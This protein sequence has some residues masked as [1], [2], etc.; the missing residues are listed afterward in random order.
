[1][2]VASYKPSSELSNL[3]ETPQT[4]TSTR[5]LRQQSRENKSLC[6][7][8]NIN[9]A[10]CTE[11]KC[12]NKRNATTAHTNSVEGSHHSNKKSQSKSTFDITLFEENRG[13]DVEDIVTTHLYTSCLNNLTSP[14]LLQL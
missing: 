7:V 10:S 5:T 14:P 12:T 9:T 11:N 8:Y 1:M 6:F 13:L 3:M 2:D 4:S